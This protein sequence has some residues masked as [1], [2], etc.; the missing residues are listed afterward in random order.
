MTGLRGRFTTWAP[1][2][3]PASTI[4]VDPPPSRLMA[5][6]APK[7]F[8]ISAV[9]CGVYA[10]QPV[11]DLDYAEDSNADSDANFVLTAKGG[12][13]EVQGTAEKTPFSEAEFMQLLN[14]A[15]KGVAEL[16]HLQRTVLG[17]E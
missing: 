15:R 1:V 7:L 8:K 13:I 17:L 11:L 6:L 10:G 2:H 4:V 16:T 9:S 14:Y 5:S 12:I 3:P